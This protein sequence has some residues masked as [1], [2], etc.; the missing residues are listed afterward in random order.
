M[1]NRIIALMVVMVL[2]LFS[3]LFGQGSNNLEKMGLGE[4]PP[5]HFGTVTKGIAAGAFGG[6][7]LGLGGACIGQLIDTRFDPLYEHHRSFLQYEQILG[8][9]AGYI[10]GSSMGVYELRTKDNIAGSYLATL[11]GSIGGGLLFAIPAPIGATIGF[12]V[13]RKYKSA[14]ANETGFINYK[15]GHLDLGFPFIYCQTCPLNGMIK[16]TINLVNVEF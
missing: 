1:K 10:L 13:T 12:N 5:L 15:Q 11:L 2:L 9:W 3:S 8:F 16:P 14:P 7:I 4:K 6:I